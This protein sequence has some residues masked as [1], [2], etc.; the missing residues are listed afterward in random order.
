[1]NRKKSRKRGLF[2]RK[3]FWFFM[4]LFLL[5]AGGAIGLLV[6]EGYTR[7][8]RDRAAG[9]DLERIND[10]EIPSIILDRNGR[11]IGR[12]FVQ[13][14][15]VISIDR[16]PEIFKAALRAGE[17]QRFDSHDG[18]DYIGI[19]RAFYLNWKAGETT[20]GASTITQQLA[21]NA[22]DLEGERRKRGESG[23][24]RKIVEAFL[25]RRI[26]KRYRKPQIMEFYLNR[27]Y[28]G[29]GYYGIRSASLG[30]FGKEP[31]E[32]NALES[33]AIV[34]CI[35]NPTNLSPLNNPEANR[36]SRNLV[37]GRMRE[38]G[39]ISRAD[40]T[41]LKTAPLPLHPR[42]LRRGTSHLY[43][44]I[45][46]SIA[47]E[48]GED[49][50]A[51][52]GFTIHTTIL[53]EAQEAAENSLLE[54]LARAESRPGYTR[55]RHDE[56]RKESGKPP[57]YLQGAVLMTD[58]VT[59][60]VLAYVGG[61]DYAQASYD[62][63]ELGTRP[64]GTAFFPFIY[65]AGLEA[66]LTPATPVEDEP[67]DN[68]S[69]MVGGREG[70]LGEWGME[71][72]SPQYEG[73]ITARRALEASKIAATVRFSDEIGLQK[74]VDMA[75]KFGLPLQG[76]ELL[77]R[78][79]VGFE[80]VSLK[81][82]VRAM[83][84]FPGGGHIGPS[85]LVYVERVVAPDGRVRFRRDHSLP[86]RP[87]V[88]DEATAWQ[89]HS[90]LAGSLFR[91]SSEG[92][93]DGLV[94]KP[95]FGAGKGGSTHDFEDCWFIGY[96]PRITCGVWTGFLSGAGAP[97]YPGA[98]SRDL[99]MPVWQATMN[100]AAPS[101]GGGN[102]APPS[103]V[104]VV[105]VCSVSG[106]RATQFCHE[107]KEDPTTGRMSS[108][109]TTVNEYFRR[110]TESLAFCSVHSGAGDLIQPG[111]A[112]LNLPALDAVPV[113]PKAPVLIGDDPYHTELPS[114]AAAPTQP[115]FMRRRT[116]VLDSLDLG[117]FEEDIP[118]R[119]PQ[120]LRI[121]EDE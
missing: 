73:E 32:L 63:I 91:G 44:R 5:I 58:H 101:F 16:V 116:N 74:I 6:M 118:L 93:L 52:G 76:A 98:F 7:P 75:V 108:V 103:N 102:L 28:F 21:R 82:L 114:F 106:Q 68:R 72:P 46:E 43:E 70:I 53:K 77:R 80:P 14:R 31:E 54:S 111:D 110:G 119:R 29:S 19:G 115:G 105:P 51:A 117:D 8:Y 96:N 61:R 48:L 88:I 57:E 25:A 56:Y 85:D 66:G 84:A 121:F 35:K 22:Y 4:L 113:Q 87:Q 86:E 20:Q 1:M 41:S 60:E 26:E 42:P 18:V 99:A 11:E 67:M 36:K 3:A 40:L 33:A 107:Y 81:Q 17:D 45:A 69:V 94:E 55:Q 47:R 62:F 2:K 9:Y 59:G 50:L 10:L 64:P 95:F 90:M 71:V 49:A 120:R 24:Q 30:Y 65:A 109:T 27:I 97:I 38:A 112:L 89:V 83:S 37:L 12:I 23:M 104:V 39:V 15:S 78:I 13:N 79:A 34:G 92:A 100:A